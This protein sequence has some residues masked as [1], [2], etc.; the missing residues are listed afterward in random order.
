ML[1]LG[2]ARHTQ[3]HLGEVVDADGLGDGFH[4][5]LGLVLLVFGMADLRLG[6]LG[7]RHALGVIGDQGVDL[8]GVHAGHQVLVGV[9]TLR[10][11]G[12]VA[13]Q[14]VTVEAEQLAGHAPGGGGQHRGEQHRQQLEAVQGARAD[15]LQFRALAFVL[16]QHPGLCA[17]EFLVDA[18][19][20]RHDVAHGLTEFTGL[21]GLLH[22]RRSG[23][24]LGGEGPGVTRIGERAVEVLGDE[25][26]GAA[27][28]VHVLADQIGVHA[29]HEVFQVQVDVVDA[30]AQLGGEVVAQPFRIQVFQKARRGDEGAARLGHLGAVHREEAVGEHRRGRAIAGAFQ[31][32]G[33]EQG[34]E[35]KDVL[36]DEVVQLS[37]FRRRLLLIPEGVE[38]EAL[39][40]AEVAEAAH[41]ADGRVQPHV[42]VLAGCARDL[43]AEIGGVAGDVPV[44]E[45][46]VQPLGQ[47]VGGLGLHLGRLDPAAQEVGAGAQLE[48]MVIGL[49]AH[50]R[51]ARNGRVGIDQVR[52]LI[53]GAAHLAGIPVLVLG[54]ALGAL[55]LDETIRQEHRLHRVVILLD[56]AH[57]DEAG[58][59]ELQV[60]IVGVVLRFRRIGGVIVVE[61]HQEA[62][63]IRLMLIPRAGDELLGR[64]P[65]LL[66]AQHD[67]CAVGVIGAHVPAFVAAH[68]LEAHPDVGLDVLHQMAQMNG[69]V[70]VGQGAGDENAA[71]CHGAYL[72]REGCLEPSPLSYHIG[73]TWKKSQPR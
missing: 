1:G 7:G 17:I 40:V 3:V 52:G 55:A 67:G 54:M 25:T 30:G 53:G 31:F 19:G 68:L 16:G 5:G 22:L 62:V 11:F 34:V 27:G 56:G 41:V 20:Y 38:V 57:L 33:P 10:Q 65:L 12:G 48:E 13:P 18:V 24:G 72:L 21:I 50:R 49:L 4:D 44:G 35:I 32:R 28:D 2:D 39:F 23:A 63:E 58:G 8:L 64:D 69:A 51:G 9:D 73:W 47:L 61:A 60:D 46:G 37:L 45:A 29:R 26:G 71:F 6:L 42:V 70:G 36:A 66:R 59:L 43:E 15:V 14:E